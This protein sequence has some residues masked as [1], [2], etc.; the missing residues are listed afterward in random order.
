MAVKARPAVAAAMLGTPAFRINDFVGR[1]SYLENLQSYN[2]AFGFKPDQESKLLLRLKE[3]LAMEDRRE[4]FARRRD[5]YLA[6]TIDPVPWHATV[7]RMVLE[8]RTLREV[9]A[10][11][12]QEYG[13]C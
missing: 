1:I 6:E 5:E 11:A 12:Q 2:L 9:R 10:W 13:L 3:L 8:G 7:V 4:L